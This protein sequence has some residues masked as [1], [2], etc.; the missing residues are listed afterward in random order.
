MRC[1][2]RNRSPIYYALYQG[3]G[4]VIDENGFETGEKVQYS[5]ATPLYAN[6]SAAKNVDTADVFGL[7]VNYDKVIVVPGRDC[8]IDEYSV[9]WVDTQNTSGPY[10]YVVRRISKSLNSTAIAIGRVDVRH[11]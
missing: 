8:P 1:A 4:P 9:L 6:V 10:D 3:V 2:L 11:A 5:P 7:D